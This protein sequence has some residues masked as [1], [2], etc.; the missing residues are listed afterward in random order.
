VPAEERAVLALQQPVET[1]EDG[2]LDASED[3]LRL[4]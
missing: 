1:T 3:D 4:L 2:P